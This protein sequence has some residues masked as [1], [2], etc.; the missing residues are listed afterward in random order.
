MLK[1]ASG[2][3]VALPGNSHNSNPRDF[4]N[5]PT[6]MSQDAGLT[7]SVLDTVV[8]ATTDSTTAVG[9]VPK[10]KQWRK[11]WDGHQ[12]SSCASLEGKLHSRE[13]L[14]RDSGS[15]TKRDPVVLA[16]SLR[17]GSTQTELESKCSLLLFYRFLFSISNAFFQYSVQIILIS[18]NFPPACD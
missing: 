10:S 9:A 14:L 5:T 3:P 11:Y 18:F 16:L 4:A 7:V 12:R 15:A 8:K 6:P 2:L 1:T 13:S 17:A